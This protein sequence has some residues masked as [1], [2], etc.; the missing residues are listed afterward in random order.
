MELEPEPGLM[1]KLIYWR[2]DMK[3]IGEIT[4]EGGREGGGDSFD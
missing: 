2:S 1:G 4:G 3:G